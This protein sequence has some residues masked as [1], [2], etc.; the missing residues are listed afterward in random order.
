MPAGVL[1]LADFLMGQCGSPVSE[2]NT[3]MVK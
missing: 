3:L 2:K 1:G